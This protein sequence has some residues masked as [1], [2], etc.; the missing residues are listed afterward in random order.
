MLEFAR[1]FSCRS[2]RFIWRLRPARPDRRFC[3][4]E[5][6]GQRANSHSFYVMDRG[7][8]NSIAY[9]GAFRASYF[10]FGDPYARPDGA[11]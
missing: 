2:K 11:P 3:R 7:G 1:T 10:F 4:F 8:G 6:G 5:S 9:V